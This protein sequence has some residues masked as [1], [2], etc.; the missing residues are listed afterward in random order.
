MT[1]VGTSTSAVG[2]VTEAV[3]LDGALDLQ[4]AVESRP[5]GGLRWAVRPN[6]SPASEADRAAVFA[7]PGFGR[8][9]TD[10]MA[11]AAW[12]ADRGW[13]DALIGP[14][15][16]FQLS[17]ASAVLHYSQSIFEG[18]K[19]YRH[20]DGSVHLF[21]PEANAARFAR[22]ARRLALPELP[23]EDFL[24]SLTELVRTEIAWVPGGGETSLYLRPLMFGDEAFLGVRPSLSAQ[25]SVIASPAGSYFTRGP[26]P[27][28]LWV[29]EHYSR[30]APGG[31]G[32]A[33]TGGN[34]AASLLPQQEAV[35]NGC[36][37]VVFLDAVEHRWIE[38]L[39]AMNVFVVRADGTVVTPPLTG[40]ILEGVT[41][42]AILAFAGELGYTPV[43]QPIALD[44]L[45]ADVRSG[46]VLEV[47]ACGT[48]AV[49]TP[50][51]RI[52]QAGLEDLVVGTGSGPVTAAPPV[53]S[54]IR[55][56]L[57]DLQYGRR[58]DPAGWL[59]QVA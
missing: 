49:V 40:A 17:P 45:R 24:S 4:P 32:A 11:T 25:Y 52:V 59:R 33:K 27:V 57:L 29:A 36:D 28:S 58:P 41:R 37:Q 53:T 55:T 39:G 21:R 26:V 20:A 18:L 9:F 22:S 48:A 38:E 16:P 46:R 23:V 19:A 30:A 5:S 10:N 3:T 31:T 6:G 43:E 50:V 2:A 12:T 15:R 56:G 47:F 7:D 13:H 42:D 51:G 34:Y 14:L 1:A 54:A 35:A 44:D 8:H